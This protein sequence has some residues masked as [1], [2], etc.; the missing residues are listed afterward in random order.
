MTTINTNKKCYYD[1]YLTYSMVDLAKVETLCEALHDRYA[2]D[3][4]M[5][6]NEAQSAELIDANKLHALLFNN[7]R[8]VICCVSESYLTRFDLLND[9]AE[10]HANFLNKRNLI[11]ILFEDLNVDK[12]PQFR[13]RDRFNFFNFLNHWS[14]EVFEQLIE[15]IRSKLDAEKIYEDMD[16]DE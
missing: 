13:E 6:L 16:M 15:L 5:D 2:L 12:Y 3:V 8:L 1:V 14:D 7:S 9:A 10:Y 11:L 4:F